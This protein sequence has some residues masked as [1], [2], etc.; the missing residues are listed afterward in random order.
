MDDG[1]ESDGDASQPGRLGNIGCESAC[2]DSG[3]EEDAQ[4]VEEQGR[5]QEHDRQDPEDLGDDPQPVE[6]GVEV[7]KDAYLRS[8]WQVLF[9]PSL[10]CL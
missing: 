7:V 4:G 2:D 6:L 9:C 1:G 8:A 3:E 5:E 10:L